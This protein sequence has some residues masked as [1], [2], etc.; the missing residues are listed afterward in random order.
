[1]FAQLWDSESSNTWSLVILLLSL[2]NKL[3]LWTCLFPFV[4]QF[5]PLYQSTGNFSSFSY[6]DPKGKKRKLY[7]QHLKYSSQ[8]ERI[9]GKQFHFVFLLWTK[10]KWEIQVWSK[11]FRSSSNKK[12]IYY[13][14]NH[15]QS[16]KMH[17]TRNHLT[18]ERNRY[19]CNGQ[20]K[21]LHT[22][23]NNVLNLS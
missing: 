14:Y 19:D 2:H 16:H 10:T 21:L 15:I 4:S 20:S 13:T 23:L 11:S 9:K 3:S 5:L 12:H 17:L 8:I 1:M 18:N 22:T 6:R 7:F